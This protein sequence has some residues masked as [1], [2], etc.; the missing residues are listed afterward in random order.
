[1]ARNVIGFCTA[2]V[3]SFLMILDKGGFAVENECSNAL[4]MHSGAIR[5]SQVKAS[6]SRDQLYVANNGRIG[7][8]HAWIPAFNN[9]SEWLQIDL[10]IKRKVSG[11]ITQGYRYCRKQQKWSKYGWE[12][13]EVCKDC[14]V[15][16]FKLKYSSNGKFWLT[17]RDPKTWHDMIFDGGLN[18]VTTWKLNTLPYPVATRYIR[19][20]PMR[21]QNAV[22]MRV[23]VMGC[24]LSSVTC[25][26]PPSFPHM[27]IV[28][29]TAEKSP[30]GKRIVYACEDG[31]RMDAKLPMF[32][33]NCNVTGHW[34][35]KVHQCVP[36]RF[37]GSAIESTSTTVKSIS[38]KSQ[39]PNDVPRRPTLRTTT[40]HDD[41]P[42]LPESSNRNTESSGK[43]L[44]DRS[45]RGRAAIIILAVL[46]AVFV[47][48]FATWIF[49]L[50][51][52]RRVQP[53]F[54][55]DTSV[56]CTKYSTLDSRISI[57]SGPGTMFENDLYGSGFSDGSTGGNWSTEPHSSEEGACA[58]AGDGTVFADNSLYGSATTLS[59]KK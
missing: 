55:E 50:R 36:C 10:L 42:T 29:G 52:P 53:E 32:V 39:L 23:E 31:F 48:A 22:A 49:F 18:T 56:T 14:S 15:T 51:K 46:L 4:G 1:M 7:N 35:G 27:E 30:Y 19:F 34:G 11:V 38:T 47:I 16:R 37:V 2:T 25:E 3:V 43:A 9:N 54:E 44:S 59:K 26:K 13:V 24:G 8:S 40:E 6:S 57:E 28:K 33:L 21:W 12:T 45:D 20:Y 17:Y 41:T 5:E 58:A